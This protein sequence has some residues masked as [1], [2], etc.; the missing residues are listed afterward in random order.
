MFLLVPYHVDVPMKRIPWMNWVLIGIT[1][2]FFPLCISAEKL[3]PL[4]ENLVAG[5][6]NPLGVVGCVLVHADLLHLL[7]NM[8]F[9]W[10]FGNAVCA[11]IG[12][13][14]YPFVYLGLGTSAALISVALGHPGIGASAAI[15]GIVGVFVVWYLFNALSCWYAFWFFSAGNSGTLEVSSYWMVLLWFVFDL[16]GALEGTGQVGYLA[17]LAGLFSGI[18]LAV[19]LL[20]TGLI[21][22]EKGECSL[23]QAFSGES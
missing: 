20:A 16:W 1:V 8:L 15:N 6:K 7:G 14:V 12:N 19:L 2:V 10:V 3:T 21:E 18:F 13:L 9:L 11:K 4:G 22:M 17:H 5:G 23:L